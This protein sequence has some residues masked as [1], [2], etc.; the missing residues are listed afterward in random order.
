[1]NAFRKM[2]R[3]YT[4]NNFK[5]CYANL[6]SRCTNCSCQSAAIY[7][8]NCD[9]TYKKKSATILTKD[10]GSSMK[11]VLAATSTPMTHEEYRK[12]SYRDISNDFYVSNYNNPP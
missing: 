12:S 3:Y 10:I 11:D 9:F 1:M 8:K 7:S 6:E 2:H 5:N 4:C